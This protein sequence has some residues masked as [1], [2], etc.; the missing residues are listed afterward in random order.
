MRSRWGAPA[1]ACA[2]AHATL[3]GR[4]R[5]ATL[6]AQEATVCKQQQER[7]PDA[8]LARQ[9]HRVAR[10]PVL[11]DLPVLEAADDDAPQLDSPATVGAM[12]GPARGDSVALGDLLIDLE[13]QVREE[14]QVSATDRRAPS[15]P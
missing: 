4:A 6:V 1:S 14:L 12:Q 9:L 8:E 5:A 13:A 2:P 11:D 15:V 10:G 3:R 7:S